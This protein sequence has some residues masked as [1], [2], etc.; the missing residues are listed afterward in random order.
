MDG[1]P[2]L[3]SKKKKRESSSKPSLLPF[4]IPAGYKIADAPSQVALDFGSEEGKGLVGKHILF[5]WRG[6]GWCEGVI[7]VQN[8]QKRQRI[9][10][11]VINFYVH[12]QAQLAPVQLSHLLASPF[13]SSP[14][15]SP[16]PPLSPLL[17]SVV[18]SFQSSY[19]SGVFCSTAG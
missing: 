6:V 16:P 19:P 9:G 3:S 10:T 8:S 14:F 2:G 4:E 13:V 1:Q 5:N 7:T 18:G 15:P 11:D 17:R 12:Y